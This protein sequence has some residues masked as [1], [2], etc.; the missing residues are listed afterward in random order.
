MKHSLA[1]QKTLQDSSVQ[2]KANN[3][4]LIQSQLIKKILQH[5]LYLVTNWQ[6]KPIWHAC[7]EYI[8]I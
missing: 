5:L 4:T 3:I 8:K 7:L 1:P 2:K 6:R